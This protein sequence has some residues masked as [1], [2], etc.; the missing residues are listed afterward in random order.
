MT[1]KN[2][3]RIKEQLKT[4]REKRGPAPQALLNEAKDQTQAQRAILSA[5][6]QGPLTVPELAQATGLG[7]RKLLWYVS[8]LRKYGKV[9]D[10]PKRGAYPSYIQ[11]KD[12][13]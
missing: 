6:G 2:F 11:Q 13:P 7:T 8:A 12:K 10:G 4:V 5:L 3:E 1:E 9:G